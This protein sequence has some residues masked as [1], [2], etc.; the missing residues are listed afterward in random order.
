M[1]RCEIERAKGTGNMISR[2]FA[3]FKEAP[4]GLK[5]HFQCLLIQFSERKAARKKVAMSSG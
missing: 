2:W 4:R 1:Q 5:L 3:S